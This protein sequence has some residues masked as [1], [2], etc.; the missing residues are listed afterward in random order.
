MITQ[1]S[2]G[3][4]IENNQ[5]S[6]T[7]DNAI[8]IYD[9]SDAEVTGNTITSAGAAAIRAVANCSITANGN[10]INQPVSHG[11][12]VS[13]RSELEAGRKIRSMEQD[14]AVLLPLT[15]LH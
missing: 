1:N 15:V 2:T 9:N 10:I 12:S 14:Q 3:C 4:T 13:D 5:L 11:I 8:Y 6:S 7:A